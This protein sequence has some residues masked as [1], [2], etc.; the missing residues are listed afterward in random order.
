MKNSNT[1]IS[2]ENGNEVNIDKIPRIL[3][4]LNKKNEKQKKCKIID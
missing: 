3:L 1:E 4:Y 2:F